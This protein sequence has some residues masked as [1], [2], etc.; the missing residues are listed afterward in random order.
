MGIFLRA[1]K[2]FSS[3]EERNGRIVIDFSNVTS[4]AD[5][6]LKIGHV[7]KGASSPFLVRGS[8]DALHDVVGDWVRENAAKRTE[9][10]FVNCNKILEIDKNLLMKLALN[11]SS[12]FMIGIAGA[13]I[14]NDQFDMFTGMNNINIYFVLN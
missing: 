13:K 6:A 8:F 9:V 1:A 11:I 4:Q 10:L 14:E 5:V 2:D 7:L 3:L 12:A